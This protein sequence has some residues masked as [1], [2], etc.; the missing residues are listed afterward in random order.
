MSRG[1][2]LLAGLLAAE[3]LGA[4]GLIG[5]GVSW[6]IGASALLDRI[7]QPP[8]SEHLVLAL[9]VPTF[10]AYVLPLGVTRSRWPWRHVDL[11][12]NYEF[13]CAPT[14]TGCARP[15]A[16]IRPTATA[17][18]RHHSRSPPRLRRRYGR[19]VRLP[20]GYR[21]LAVPLAVS[22]TVAGSAIAVAAMLRVRRASLGLL[23][24]PLAVVLALCATSLWA[25]SG[26][27]TREAGFSS[28]GYVQTGIVPSAFVSCPAPGRCVAFGTSWAFQPPGELAAVALTTD[29]GRTWHERSFPVG[30]LLDMTHLPGG[31]GLLALPL[32]A[33]PTLQR[34]FVA[35]ADYAFPLLATELP[36]ARSSD[37][38]KSWDILPAPLGPGG[39]ELGLAGGFSCMTGSRCV[40][41]DGH[42]A[43]ITSD[44][45]SSWQLLASMPSPPATVR[46]SSGAVCSDPS[47][48]VVY[49]SLESRVAT[50]ATSSVRSIDRTVLL[51]TSD[52][53]QVWRR[54]Q[55]P[56]NAGVVSA[57]WCGS[58][59][60]CVL[61][62]R[63]DSAGP[64]DPGVDQL[65]VSTDWGRH[66]AL[67][68][69]DETSYISEITC[70]A[71][72]RCL[73]L[74]LLGGRPGLLDSRD[75]GRSWSLLLVG[76]FTS[77]SC[78][79]SRFCAVA[80]TTGDHPS[81]ER[82]ILETTTDGGKF[83]H[84]SAF[85][86]IPVPTNQRPLRLSGAG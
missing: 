17:P 59:G 9:D 73:A 4:V 30:E 52:G 42:A 1:R 3:A 71:V 32:V 55:L 63:T 47:H 20:G 80:G 22:S 72:S 11:A 41:A 48:C 75:G 12:D 14:C 51:W 27:T 5:Y 6:V 44:A 45:G 39:T 37:G 15:V 78:T 16:D 82:A 84:S 57:L 19:R 50:S 8:S 69:P 18:P 81:T 83:W 61:S 7:D 29:G 62:A 24:V 74:G 58:S 10:V 60:R 35:R 23:A 13:R 31:G 33:C 67:Y 77:F 53:G 36:V 28:A 66:W 56:A 86:T 54:S 26:P 38:G 70:D 49:F 64:A 34:C 76:R 40:L 46:E 43:V 65:A 21:P 25:A 85:P 68:P 2:A 79:G